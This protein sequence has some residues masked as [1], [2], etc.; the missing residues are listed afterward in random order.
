MGQTIFCRF[1]FYYNPLDMG[2]YID[3]STFVFD[4]S[5][6]D[7]HTDAMNYNGQRVESVKPGVRLDHPLELAPDHVCR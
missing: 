1:N 7:G 6:T 3:L 4:T 2:H 5:E